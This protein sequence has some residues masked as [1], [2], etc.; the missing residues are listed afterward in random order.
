MPRKSIENSESTAND[1]FQASSVTPIISCNIY[2]H[3]FIFVIQ[4]VSSQPG[5]AIACQC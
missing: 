1:Q 2:A 4:Y 3:L 5:N